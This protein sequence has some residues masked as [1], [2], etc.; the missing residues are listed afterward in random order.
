MDQPVV[1]LRLFQ[2]F[3][4]TFVNAIF[5]SLSIAQVPCHGRCQDDFWPGNTAILPDGA[6]QH[7]TIHLRHSQ[8]GNDQIE[9]FA[10]RGRLAQRVQ[11]FGS[12]ADAFAFQPPGPEVM[13]Q[14]FAVGLVVVHD[15]NPLL[16]K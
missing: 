12:T 1:E 2:R 9:R 8:V 10:F 6:R 7:Q 4:E 13:L 11:C 5:A 3:D 16:R 14:H 15:Q